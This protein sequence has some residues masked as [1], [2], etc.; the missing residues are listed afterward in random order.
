MY[1]LAQ[2]VGTDPSAQSKHQAADKRKSAKPQPAETPVPHQLPP[3]EAADTD[4]LA[5]INFD[6]VKAQRVPVAGIDSVSGEQI[7]G[8]RVGTSGVVCCAACEAAR[9]TSSA[10]FYKTLGVASD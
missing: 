5:A 8:L 9:E 6:L 2:S 3:K 1:T 4:T 7:T 10:Q